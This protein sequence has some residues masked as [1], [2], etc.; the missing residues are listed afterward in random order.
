MPY[1][2][3]DRVRIRALCTSFDVEVIDAENQDGLWI[4]RCRDSAGQIRQHYASAIIG[5]ATGEEAKP[6]S[7]LR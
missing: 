2:T 7:I 5:P 3:G 1:K 4:Y 6:L